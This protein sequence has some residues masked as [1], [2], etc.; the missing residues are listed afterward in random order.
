[1][2]CRSFRCPAV[3]VL[4][5]SPFLKHVS[6]R[7]GAPKP[8]GVSAGSPSSRGGS[9]RFRKSRRSRKTAHFGRASPAGPQLATPAVS[10]LKP[11]SSTPISLADCYQNHP[12]ESPK[13]LF[14]L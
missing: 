5:P 7:P 2:P 3:R 9:R 6:G 11:S 8:M 12:H 14:S 4:R 13:T 1:M 10:P